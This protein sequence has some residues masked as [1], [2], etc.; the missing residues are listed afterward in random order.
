MRIIFQILFI[1]FVLSTPFFVGWLVSFNIFNF[2]EIDN[3]WIGFWGGYLGG[4]YTLIGVV[5]TISFS[6]T[7]SSEKQRLSVIPY[8]SI[9]RNLIVNIDSKMI[10]MGITYG[11]SDLINNSTYF[12][13]EEIEI[14]NNC[15]NVGLGT[16][17]NC[18]ISDIKIGERI[19]NQNTQ[20]ESV[21][22][23][24]SQTCYLINFLRIGLSKEQLTKEFVKEYE[25][26]WKP[27]SKKSK[28]PEIKIEFYFNF[29]DL[30]GN[31][32][33]QKVIYTSQIIKVKECV[34]TDF[35]LFFRSIDKPELQEKRNILYNWN[36]KPK[37]K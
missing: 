34:V 21:L 32:Y 15:T 18:F 4:L 12:F 3:D 24:N 19:I 31:K 35:N 28:L 27:N 23:V 14:I 9:E 20:K 37:Q 16:V 25:E 11:A 30:L 5:M 13:F 26:F 8:I 33:K 36:M 22:T 1:I 6:K 17:I 2:L 10:N 7:N 29:E